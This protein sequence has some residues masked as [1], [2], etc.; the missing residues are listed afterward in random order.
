MGMQQN[1]PALPIVA[2]TTCSRAAW[3][4]RQATILLSLAVPSLILLVPHGGS[5]PMGLLA[6][7]GI[8]TMVAAQWTTTQRAFLTEE[9]QLVAALLLFCCI[10][11]LSLFIAGASRDAVRELDTLFRPLLAV[12]FLYLLIRTR[13]P[14]G[15]L[16]FG[17]TIGSILAG[18]NAI[19][20][21]ATAEHY[22]RASGT[23][24]PILYGNLALTMGL[25]ATAGISYFSRFGKPWTLIPL[26]AFALSL[27][28]SFLSGSRGGWIALPILGSAAV[29]LMWKIGPLHHYRRGILI[30]AVGAGIL[31]LAFVMDTGVSDRLDDG[32]QEFRQ[33]L[34]DPAVY[35]NTSVGL[36]LEMWQAAWDM[37]KDRPILGSGIGDSYQEFLQAEAEK[38]NYH[39]ATT[40]FDQPHNEYMMTLA[41]RGLIGLIS[42]LALWLVPARF[43]LQAMSSSSDTSQRLGIAGLLLVATFM[44]FGLTESIMHRGP[45]MTFF[46]FHVAF[47][48][49]LL[50]QEKIIKTAVKRTKGNPPGR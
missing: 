30:L 13:P 44:V 7:L 16:W 5:A 20:E 32:M 24:N 12:P 9:K 27:V 8:G 10:V 3:L 26:I 40:Q 50:C 22:V 2:A 19:I 48:T 35:G 38:G 46:I 37:F 49:Y 14:E 17:V 42:L 4:L 18:I 36:R 39:T 45:P 28:A 6:L 15:L 1:D 25:I 31:A 23:T 33:Y 41:T 21:V 29:Y 11:L 43:F 47:I 34:Q